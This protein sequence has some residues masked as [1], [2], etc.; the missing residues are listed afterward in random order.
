MIEFLNSFTYNL[1]EIHSITK[2][3]NVIGLELKSQIVITFKDGFQLAAS[4]DDQVW[5]KGVLDDRV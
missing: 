3:N 1:N 5:K 4:L 2:I